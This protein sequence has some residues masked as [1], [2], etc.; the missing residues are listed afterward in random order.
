VLFA[1]GSLERG[2]SEGQ[3]AELISH[4]HPYRVSA[5]VATLIAAHDR[6]HTRTLAELGV[7][8][9]VLSRPEGSRARRATGA[10]R[11]LDR[12]LRELRPDAVYAW[13][14]HVTALAVPLARR[15]GVPVLVA[16]RDAG[17]RALAP[18]GPLR[19]AIHRAEA[20]ADVVTANSRAVFEACKRRGVRP[21]RLRLVPNGHPAG[22]ALPPP[23]PNGEPVRLGYVAALRPEK[24]HR[25]LMR[26]LRQVRAQAPWR[27]DLAGTGPL[28]EDLRAEAAANGLSDRVRFM[29]MVDDIPGFW[30]A[31]GAGLLLSDTEG[32][33]NA[34]IETA[35]A[36]RPVVASDVPGNREVVEPGGGLLVA[37][38]DDDA[39][40]RAVE[41][42]VDDDALRER[43]GRCA[44]EQALRR[45]AIE[46]MVAGHLD[47]IRAANPRCACS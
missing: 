18:G 43:L 24:G 15:R 36:G 44:R 28:L 25:R 35:L 30:R 12:L 38:G 39:I 8:H 27:V 11:R 22:Q 40:A 21:E 37:A 19:A 20:R 4:V 16:R 13:G 34:L 33:P 10:S 32:C 3:L 46:P 41:R 5:T 23:A 2:G 29:G 42:I 9:V 1:I 47:A 14:G 26:V 6:R 7:P 17:V 45:F 31:R